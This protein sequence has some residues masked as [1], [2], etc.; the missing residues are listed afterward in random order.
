[1]FGNSIYYSILGL[2]ERSVLF[3]WGERRKTQPRRVECWSMLAGLVLSC[4][5]FLFFTVRCVAVSIVG[6]LT[7][8]EIRFAYTVIVL[9]LCL[10][11]FR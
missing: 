8:F 11:F 2:F 9:L 3:G 1:M 7:C 6:H 5:C 4:F 10:F